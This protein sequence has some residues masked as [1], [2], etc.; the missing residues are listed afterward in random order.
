VTDAAPGRSLTRRHLA[1]AVLAG[2]A[3]ASAVTGRLT[4]CAGCDYD[5]AGVPLFAAGSL[6]YLGLGLLALLGTPLRRLGWVSLPGVVVQAGLVR[7]LLTVGVPCATCLAAAAS[8]FAVSLVCL[9]PEGRWRLAP[10]VTA[11]LGIVILP[12]WTGLLV[13]TERPGALPDFARQ[14]DL[15]SP[16][17]GATLLVVYRKDGCSY[18]R[19]FETQYEKRL[20]AEFGAGLEVR[21]IDVHDRGPVGRLPSF[22]VR[23]PDGSLLLIR[24]L[25]S[26][27]DLVSNIRKAA[28]GK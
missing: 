19:A 17:E 16:A 24:G 1:A 9:W 26:Y 3:L 8:L 20:A 21:R 4:A 27:P 5:I 25:P 14:G 2:S 6:Y 23:P 10:G 12:L 11:L 13:E 7:F 22:L 28:A 15:R 18:C